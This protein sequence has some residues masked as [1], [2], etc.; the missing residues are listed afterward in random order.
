MRTALVT[1]GNRGIGFEACRQLAQAG[2]DVILT[3]RDFDAGLRAAERLEAAGVGVSVEELDIADEDSVERC[4][5]RLQDGGRTVDALVN[6]AGIYP[7]GALLDLDTTTLE[8][9]FRT[10][11]MGAFWTCRSFVPG[12]V[13]RGYGRVV[14][15]SSGYGSFAEGLHGPAAYSISKASLNAFTKKLASETPPEVKV[16]AL[17]PGWVRTRMGGPG[18]P[19]TPEEAADTVV[20]LATLPADGPTGQIFRDRRAIAW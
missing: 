8:D 15:V 10:N 5:K 9:A 1:G 20:W 7:Q 4:T 12:M 17:C 19:R 13:R 14:N 11:V 6:N 3:A 2:L 16:N 18:A